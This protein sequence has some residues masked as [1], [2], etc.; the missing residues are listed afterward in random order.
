MLLL[1]A[2]DNKFSSLRVHQIHIGN[3]SD[4]NF[5]NEMYSKTKK[6]F[7]FLFGLIVLIFI[8]VGITIYYLT[9]DPFDYSKYSAKSIAQKL[10]RPWF[11]LKPLDKIDISQSKIVIYWNSENRTKISCKNENCN[12]TDD[13]GKCIENKREINGNTLFIRESSCYLSIPKQMINIT[14]WR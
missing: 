6:V 9:E 7:I 10:E 8:G 12:K 2:Y 14:N 5:G 1:N 11:E 3:Q 4:K 13:N